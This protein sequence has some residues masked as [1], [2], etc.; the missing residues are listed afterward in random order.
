MDV[1]PK[2][3]SDEPLP[4]HNEWGRYWWLIL[5]LLV[6]FPIPIRHWWLAVIFLALFGAIVAMLL[7]EGK[8]PPKDPPYR[9]LV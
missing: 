2:Q 3:S 6:F 9:T 8:Q 4:P 7:A 5:L 1:G